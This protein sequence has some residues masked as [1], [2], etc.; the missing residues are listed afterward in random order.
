I[1][2]WPGGVV[3]DIPVEPSGNFED[4]AAS[5]VWTLDQV[6]NYVKQDLW[7]IPG[8]VDSSKYVDALFSTY[9]YTGTATTNNIVNGVDLTEGGL[10]WFK[11]R[12]DVEDHNLVDSERGSN[13]G[14]ESNT[15]DAETGSAGFSTFNSN[16]FTLTGGFGKT[17]STSS[18]YTSW[19]FR[20]KEKFFDIVTY[21]GDDVSGR[22]IAHNLGSTPGF[23]IVK[24]TSGTYN[25]QI[26]H[27]SIGATKF[28][29][30][31]TGA[32]QTSSAVWNDTAPT[33]AVFTVGNEY[34]VN[35][36]GDTYVAYLFASDAGGFGDDGTE[37]IIKCGS[38]AHNY[39]GATVDCGFEPQWILVKAA[40]QSNNWYIFDV[41]RG[42]VTGGLS[43]DGD[44]A[45]FPNTSGAENVNTWGIDVNATGF[46]VYGN[47][48]LSSGNAI[49]IAIRRSMKTPT[50]GT[51]VFAPI[52]WTGDGTNNRV[53]PTGFDVD[54]VWNKYDLPSAN[55]RGISY[56]RLTSSEYLQFDATLAA[57]TNTL[58]ILYFD[59]SNGIDLGD[60][61]GF[62]K[63]SS[64]DDH[65]G[66]NFKRATGFFDVVAY[67]GNGTAGATQA[68]NLGVVPELMVFKNRNAVTHWPVYY[69]NS[70]KYMHLSLNDAESN[71]GSF[72]NSTSPTTSL[73]TVG[74]SNQVNGSGNGMVAYLFASL[75]GVSKVGSYTGTGADL[76]VDCGFSAGARFILIKRTDSTGD[77]YV[78]DSARGI[79]AGD[80]PYVLLNSV[81]AEVTN[82][83]YID[84]LSSGFTV[85]SSA[86]AALNASGGTY[87]FLAI[88]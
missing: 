27:S 67:T 88:A 64:G 68:H 22:E 51:E 1:K 31:T 81:A 85:T 24:K 72:W 63:N 55:S 25:W 8:N 83:D 78:Y 26:Y 58:G 6:A 37:N 69:G 80:D 10:V 70:G 17:N 21:T 23:M 53:L 41:M 38:F 35:Q 84:P 76:N 40:D 29:E 18:T 79:V 36:S 45:L 52:A 50:A 82:T 43:G 42:I 66:Y 46:T 73:F 16:G 20:K 9:L 5:G 32:S 74:A 3:T 12:D 2:D 4:S 44:A 77:W 47:N 87:I 39:S 7:P 19:T 30:F 86:P 28:L 75:A 57:G 56:N 49:Y 60:S 71:S 15:T 13:K 62:D 33:D 11:T 59:L 48:I 34:G 65:V 61:G 14:L 54:A